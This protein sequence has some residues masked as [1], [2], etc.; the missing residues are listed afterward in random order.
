[1]VGGILDEIRKGVKS[2]NHVEVGT[3]EGGKDYPQERSG[4]DLYK[5][6]EM[7]CPEI[8]CGHHR[9]RCALQTQL[10]HE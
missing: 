10:S 3:I 5:T 7:N 6:T 4:D 1:M 9:C 2:H 8:I